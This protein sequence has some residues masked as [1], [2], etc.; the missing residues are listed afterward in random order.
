MPVLPVVSKETCESVTREIVSNSSFLVNACEEIIKDNPQIAILINEFIKLTA[1]EK[2]V[3]T[4]VVAVY[5][6]LKSQA[7]ADNLKKEFLL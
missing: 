3:I 6:L 1:D 2:T 7:E 5:K 4:T